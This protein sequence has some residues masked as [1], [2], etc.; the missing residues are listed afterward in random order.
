[1]EPALMDEPRVLLSDLAKSIPSN[2]SA[3][4]VTT[5]ALWRWSQK[6][7]KTKDGRVVKLEVLRIGNRYY[8]SREALNRFIANQQS[9]ASELVGA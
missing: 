5:Q 9:H 7:V 4:H 3:T 6:G 2:R 1:M 8:S